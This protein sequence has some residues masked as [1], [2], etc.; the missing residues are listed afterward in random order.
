MSSFLGFVTAAVFLAAVIYMLK[1]FKGFKI[2]TLEDVLREC[3][4]LDN[5]GEGNTD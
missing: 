5:N 1:A 2:E 4:E 3:E